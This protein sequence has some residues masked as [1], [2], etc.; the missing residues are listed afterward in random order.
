MYHDDL[1]MRE[2][3]LYLLLALACK[4]GRTPCAPYSVEDLGSASDLWIGDGETRRVMGLGK[5]QDHR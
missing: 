5:M 3:K 4:S 1:R 2:S